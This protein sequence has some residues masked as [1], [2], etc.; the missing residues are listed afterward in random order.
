M[1]FIQ[2]ETRELVGPERLSLLGQREQAVPEQRTT[3]DSYIY[4]MYIMYIYM[5]IYIYI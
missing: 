1:Q 3:T 2:S 4:I 5:Y